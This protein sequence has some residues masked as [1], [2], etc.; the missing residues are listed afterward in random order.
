MST[1]V[2]LL[3]DFSALRTLGCERKYQLTC[4]QGLDT[5]SKAT[6]F[7]SAFHKYAEAR[8]RGCQDPAPVL[9]V[10]CA[11]PYS[12]DDRETTRLLSTA[13]VWDQRA[14][15]VEPV[16]DIDRNPLVEWKF[17]FP[18]L[19]TPC[20]RIVLCGTV[21]LVYIENDWIQFRDYKTTAKATGLD[22]QLA[23]Y[24]SSFQIPFYLYALQHHLAH[25]LEPR[26]HELLTSGRLSG[27]YQMI[28]H[29]FTPAKVADSSPVLPW[30]K[31]AIE[32]V[33]HPLIAN[34]IKIADYPHLAPPT[35]M[36]TGVCKNCDYLPACRTKD[37][38]RQMNMLNLYPR[39]VYNPMEFR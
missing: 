3:I 22:S 38:E 12:L 2:D 37:T 7:G 31:E 18:Y 4:L 19:T 9:V 28:Y 30:T 39:R 29:S 21:D 8:Q 20:Y 25:L 17:S 33:L 36:A 26:A 1:P 27:H 6:N 34:A 13:M 35:G 16:R 15:Y 14:A 10:Q 23:E 24:E 5:S 11:Q 32:S